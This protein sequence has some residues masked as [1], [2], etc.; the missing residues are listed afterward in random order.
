MNYLDGEQKIIIA[1]DINLK[2][3]LN[4]ISLKNILPNL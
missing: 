4:K 3:K 2:I 1:K